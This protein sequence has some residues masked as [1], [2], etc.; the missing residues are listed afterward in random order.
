MVSPDSPSSCD[1]AFGAMH[2]A[3]RPSGK[4]KSR[5]CGSSEGIRVGAKWPPPVYYIGQ[6]GSGVTVQSLR[7]MRGINC[8]YVRETCADTKCMKVL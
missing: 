4:V 3:Y 8:V 6:A 2:G 7:F 1:V 5:W